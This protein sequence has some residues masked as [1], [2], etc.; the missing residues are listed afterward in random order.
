MNTVLNFPQIH[1]E[2]P[3][4]EKTNA[5]A[6]GIVSVQGEVA[7]FD[8]IAAGLAAIEAAHPK[9]VIVADIAT[10]AGMKLAE[11][12]WRA[13]RNPRLEVERARKAAKAPVLAL[14]KAIDTFAGGLEDRLRAGEDHYK[15][16]IDTEEARREA[17]RAEAAAKE[18]QRKATHT[19]NLATIGAYLTRCQAPGMT[20]ERIAAGIAA[21][22][23]TTF[24][25]EWE[26]F[27]VLAANVQCETIESM[28]TLH[29]QAVAREAEAAR[30]EAIRVEN[31]RMAREL[32][33]E[34]Q[35][36]AAEVA[37]IRRQQAEWA[38]QRAEA[39]RI[40][41]EAEDALVDSLHANSRRIEGPAVG[42]VQKAIGYFE[43]AAR[44]WEADPRQRVRDAVGEGR[45]Y[46]AAQLATAM[47]NERDEAAAAELLRQARE[48]NERNA[49]T[50]QSTTDAHQPEPAPQAEALNVHE[51]DAAPGVGQP[52]QEAAA[53]IEAATPPP[54]ELQA[55][56]AEARASKFPSQPKMGLD[57]WNRFYALADA[58]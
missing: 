41:R 42:Y 7:K 45:R 50:E 27:A 5:I 23:A 11:G 21:L 28:R 13:Y 15:A 34:R 18:A 39:E 2:P 24:G 36:I 16:Q 6:A 53:A 37:E 46:L 8:Q 58:P 26:E 29:A 38:A 35:R 9:D 4:V 12:A 33:A 52:D 48:L 10:T 30:Q 3:A 22:E 49:S 51:A 44:D 20:A 57:W 56:A 55:L 31:E 54:T 40:A 17:V 47:D 19:A 32:E 25:P 14:V 1:E 43:T